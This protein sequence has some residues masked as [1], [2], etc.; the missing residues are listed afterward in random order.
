[1]TLFKKHTI[2]PFFFIIVSCLVFCGLCVFISSALPT[3]AEKPVVFWKMIMSQI[4]LGFGGGIL[5]VWAIFNIPIEFFKK[6]SLHIFIA[7]CVLTLL[8]FVP[9]IGMRHGGAVRWISLKVISFQPSE[10][11][12]IGTVL[13]LAAFYAKHKNRIN[14]IRYGILPFLIACLCASMIIIQPDLGTFGIVAISAFMVFFFAGPPIKHILGVMGFGVLMFLLLVIIE[15]YRMDRIRTFFNPQHDILGTSYQLDQSQ[16]ALGSGG[17]T[18]RGYG[19]SLQKFST[20]C[21][22][23]HH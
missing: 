4:F 20:P 1:M 7:A 22:K 12:K 14:D 17:F 6:Y 23:F 8:V 2:D 10:F 13:V 3:L 19:Q 5:S 9:G 11:M 21:A 15:P 18:G 16:I